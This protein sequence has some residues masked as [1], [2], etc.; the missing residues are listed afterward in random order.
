MSPT[1][2]TRFQRGITPEW[3]DTKVKNQGVFVKHWLCPRQ[4]QSPK[5][6]FLIQGQSQGHKVIDLG[7]NLKGFISG[8]FMPN[9]KYLS[10]T[11]QKL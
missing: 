4:Q 6:Y 1:G 9:M 2:P 3:K 10:L 11:V 5:R 7:V 8:A